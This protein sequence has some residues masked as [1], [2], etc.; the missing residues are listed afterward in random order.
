MLNLLTSFFHE[1]FIPGVLKLG[2][3]RFLIYFKFFNLYFGNQIWNTCFDKFSGKF[4]FF[5]IFIYIKI[6]LMLK[7]LRTTDLFRYCNFN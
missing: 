5:W 1:V 6:L 2:T 7:N 3:S 4:D